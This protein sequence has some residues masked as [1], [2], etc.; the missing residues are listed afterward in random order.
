M[1]S[2]VLRS[3]FWAVAYLVSPIPEVSRY[4]VRPTLIRFRIALLRYMLASSP[5]TF[6]NSKLR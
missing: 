2:R 6:R 1:K 3:A 5:V 4:A